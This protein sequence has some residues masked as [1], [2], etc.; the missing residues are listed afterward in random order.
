MSKF[1]FLFVSAGIIVSD[2]SGGSGT[3]MRLVNELSK[4][5]YNVGILMIKNK[6]VYNTIAR[7][8]NDTNIL[9]PPTRWRDHIPFFSKAEYMVFLRILELFGKTTILSRYDLKNVK[10]LFS[11]GKITKESDFL[12]SNSWETAYIVEE[13]T[14]NVKE[15]YQILQYGD[16][17]AFLRD[18]VGENVKFVLKTFEFKLSFICINNYDFNRFV[19]N[20]NPIMLKEGINSHDWYRDYTIKKVPGFI[21]VPLRRHM[22]K[23]AEIAIRSVE[24]ILNLRPESKIKSF[25]DYEGKLPFGTNHLGFV[26]KKE[27]FKLY[28]EASI[29][30]FPSIGEGFGLT[31]LEAMACGCV[32]IASDNIG[33][34]EYIQN[35]VNGYIV[36]S[37]DA[38]AISKKT[39]ELLEDP[40]KTALLSKRAMETAKLFNE[41][42]MCDSFLTGVKKRHE[43]FEIR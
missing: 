31:G 42:N 9:L 22:E 24:Q 43:D 37:G 38:S 28:N 40:E 27:L 12:I 11:K 20:K 13:Y 6:D 10:I 5:G 19:P 4:R 33:V 15:K 29:F 16:N 34:R 25:G 14:G 18:Y 26:S 2:D 41:K 17:E 35:G 32:V 30:I 8:T 21:L 3:M 7:I 39:I 23:G 36:P 1:D